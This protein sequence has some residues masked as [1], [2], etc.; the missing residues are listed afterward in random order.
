[1][2]PPAAQSL[3]VDEK[4]SLDCGFFCRCTSTGCKE[5][6]RHKAHLKSHMASFHPDIL[7]AQGEPRFD[8]HL[9]N[10]KFAFNYAL[11]THLE[12]HR[13]EERDLARGGVE[14]IV[15]GLFFIFL[16]N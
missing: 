3:Q 7:E 15:V 14:E 8:C 11:K 2:D 13:L 4:S 16:F 1:M 12:W 10:R 5:A 6:F 9:C